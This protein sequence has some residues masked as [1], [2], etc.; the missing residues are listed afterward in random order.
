[1]LTRNFVKML[2]ALWKGGIYGTSSEAVTIK[3]LD[4]YQQNVTIWQKSS[5]SSSTYMINVSSDNIT[6]TLS[7]T[8][9]DV[10]TSLTTGNGDFSAFAF[11]TG[12]ATPTFDDNKMSG[13]LITTLVIDANT[14]STTIDGIKT[15]Y[16]QNLTVR[17]TGTEAVTIKEV[18]RVYGDYSATS[19]KLILLERTVLDAPLTLAPE[20]SGVIRLTV[21]LPIV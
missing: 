18:G 12:D 19:K 3:T 20:E 15:K 9:K 21:N 5:S 11:G 7:Y 8:I 1:M 4:D 2:H 16:V 13:A 6:R 17:N 10:V 14:V